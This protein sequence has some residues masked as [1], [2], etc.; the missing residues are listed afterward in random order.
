MIRLDLTKASLVSF[1]TIVEDKMTSEVKNRPNGK[2]PAK[3][4]FQPSKFLN[5][6]FTETD[7]QGFKTWAQENGN[8]MSSM[9]DKLLDDGYS[10]SVKFDSFSSAFA[11]F[12]QTSDASNENVGYILSGRSR[13]ASMAIYAVLYRHYVLFEGVW[14]LRL[15]NNNRMDDE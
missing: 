13:S 9:L 6:T 7:K 2:R 11:A 4:E 1:P 12:I 5:H 8:E 15:A 10:L 3:S 14:P